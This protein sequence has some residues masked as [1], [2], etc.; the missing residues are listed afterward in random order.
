MAD[1]EHELERVSSELED[2]RGN[3]GQVMEILQVI[4]AK[5][6][7]QTTVVSEI[8]GPSVEPQPARAVPTTWPTYGLPPGFTPTVEG[9][10]GFAPPAQQ[11]APLPTINE[12]HPVVHTFA[13]PLVRAHVQP[14]FEDQQHAPDFSDEDEERQEDLR[15]MKENYQMLEKRL[16]AMEGDQVFGATAKEMCLVSGL[17]IP[18]KFRT[19]DFDKY[20]GHSC[21]KS[22]LIM[23]YR[24]MAAHVEDDKLMIHCFQDSL[25]GAPSKWYLSLDQSK[26][27]C[28]QDLSDAFIQHYKYNMDMAPDRRQLLNL[29]EKKI[30]SFRDVGPNVK[31]NPLPAH[32]DVNAVE[33]ASD[34]CVIKNVEDVKTPLLAL[35]AGLVKARLIDTCHDSCEDCVIQPKGCKVVR[36]DIQN[37]MNQGVLQISGPTINEEISVIEPVF[38]IPEPFEVTYHKRDDVHPSP[39]VVCMPTPFPFESTKA[40]PWKYDITVVDGVV[41][42]K[43]EATESKKGMENVNADITNIAGT[44]RMTRS[45]RIYTPNFDVNPQ[46][47]TRGAT[48]VNPT[49]EQGGAQSA[50]QTDEAKTSFQALE[51]SNATLEEVKDPVEKASLSFASLKSAKSAV[52]SGGP[53][54]WG[55]V[56]NVNEKNDRFVEDDTED[57]EALN[58]VYRC[59]AALTNWEAV[60]IP[61]LLHEYVDV[62]AWSYQDMPGLDTDIVVHKLPLQPDCPPVKQKLRRARPDMALKICDEVKRQF[63]AGFLAVAKYPQWV[64]NIVPV[65]KKDGKVRMCVD[66]RDL[67]KASPK[68]D[69]PLP[70]IDTLVDNTAKFAVFS[71]MDGFSGYNQIKMDPEDME[72]TTFI[73]PWGTFCYKVMPFGLKNAGATYQRAMVTL[74]HDMMHKEIEVY[75]DD[76]I[77]K[78]QSEEDHIDHLQKLFERLRKFRLR[79]NPAKCTFGVRSGKLLGFI[80]SQRGIEVDPD[81]VRAIQE[82]PA[83]RTEREVR[84]FLGR[85]NYIS[86]FISHMTA[87]C[88]PIFK[89][90][91]KDQAVEWNSDCQMAFERIGQYLQESPILIPPVQGRPLFMYLTV[92]EKSMGCVLGQHDE[93][94]R[95]EHAIYYLS[96]RFTDCETRYSLLEK[97]CC[98]LAWAARRLRQYMICHTTLLISK[99]DPIKY[100]FEKPALTGRLARWQMLLSE[101]D[102]QYVSQ[103]AIKGSVLSDYLANQ[104][105][106]DYQPLK[107]D[108]PDEDIM[109]VKDCEIPGPDEGPEPG[110]RWK[111]MFDARLCFDCTNNI[112][113]YE[114]CI[115]GIEAA[116]DLR[117]KILEVCGDSA[118]VIYQVKGEW[119]TRDTKLIPYR[120]YVMELIKYFDEITFRHIPRTENQIADALAMLASMYQVRF[121]NEAPLIQIERK[122]EP[123][124]CQSVEEEVDGKPWFHDIKCFLQ[125]QE[126]PTDATTLDKKTLRKLASKFF[127]SNG[128][129]YKR[130]H[131]MILL[132][133]VDEREADLLIKEIHEGSFGTHANGHAMAKKIL[134]A[135]N[136]LTSPWPFSMWGID[137]IGAIEPKAS[138]GH[139][140]I[141]VAIDYFTKWVEAASYANVTKQ[142]VARFL[143]KEIICRYGIPNRIITDNGTNLNNKTMK[144]LCESFKIEHHNSSPYRPKMNGAVEAANKNIKKI[145]V[146]GMEAVLPIE[147]EIPSMRIL[148]ETKLEEAEWIQNRFDQLNLIDEK[149]LTSLCHGQLYQKR[150]KRAF[151]KKVRVREFR[152]GDLVLKKILPIHKDSRGKWTPNYEGPYVVK[153][154]FSGGALILTTMD[155]EELSHPVNSDAV[156]K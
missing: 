95:K 96:K 22:H 18:A 32:G 73:T 56:I 27:R 138:N 1:Q 11:T 31:N 29:V 120:A 17:V 54:G 148:M 115:L 19:P 48:N 89:L 28:F 67:N 21:P 86:R 69:F 25:R 65:P 42:G 88:E 154:A 46:E 34:V 149:R 57:E 145:L 130:N 83:P 112:A 23:Y 51:I 102:I 33:D 134:R 24:K 58:L 3:M 118:L 16:R 61:E 98:A 109:V 92:L 121:H 97:T 8:A 39:V 76:M 85:L 13:P 150:L 87:T 59:E 78:S 81:K 126:Y 80:V 71:F 137:M 132:R 64:A 77:A 131:D 66:Y 49:P 70:H 156:K 79:L 111:L 90:L 127:L 122:V 125:N 151:D 117:I 152:E 52:E 26:I 108:F 93:T 55:Q 141:L 116:I 10:P 20:E 41:D 147:V 100:I 44:S 106:E 155:D 47:S 38:N 143:K 14:Y 74:F 60:E 53:A 63:D 72:K 153:K 5:L 136:V 43:P 68:D 105:V 107:F 103:K 142:V 62:F 45:G 91:R 139:R 84:G 50:V 35:H 129:L 30:L 15:G 75:V 146:Y 4:R 12:N 104:P 40:V 6:D 123:A 99:M 82:M 140:F 110:S 114:A 36:N 128:V 144:E 9:A 133:C 101:Y 2:L 124:Y 119:E 37:L 135:V 94:G 7:T 113:E